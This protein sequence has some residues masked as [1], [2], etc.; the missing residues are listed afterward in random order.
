ML[1]KKMK[2]SAALLL[3]L[4]LTG[5]H[6]QQAILSSGGNNSGSGGSVSYSV[7]QVVYTTNTGTSGSVASGVQQPIEI[8]VLTGLNDA[9]GI[10]LSCS[11]Y[12]NPTSDFLELKIEGDVK[13]QY[14]FSL[15]SMTGNLIR[16]QQVE[17]SETQIDMGKLAVSTYFLRIFRTKESTLAHEIKSFKIIKN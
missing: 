3:G 8:S 16:T 11:V 17:A 14:T 9:S 10:N 12:P 5:L 4:G 6:A 15:Y 1:Y 7:G 2:L 13:T